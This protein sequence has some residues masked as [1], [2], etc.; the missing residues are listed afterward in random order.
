MSPPTSES[1]DGNSVG[2]PSTELS[3]GNGASYLPELSDAL[4]LSG[5]PEANGGMLQS[6]ISSVPLTSPDGSVTPVGKEGEKLLHSP[7][8]TLVA[9]NNMI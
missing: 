7:A 1:Q 3:V 6:K 9:R 2:T 4:A 5:Q 8:S